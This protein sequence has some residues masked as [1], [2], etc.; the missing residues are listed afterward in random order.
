MLVDTEVAAIQPVAVALVIL[1]FVAADGDLTARL[2]KRLMAGILV[3]VADTPSRVL[4]EGDARR[5]ARVHGVYRLPL[6][7]VGGSDPLAKEYRRAILERAYST[8]VVELAGR[9]VVSFPVRV[10]AL[11]VDDTQLPL[12][13]LYAVAGPI[14]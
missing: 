14:H 1:V 10:H 6:G 11:D 4:A 2:H 13:A 9:V 7:G 3:V 12:A 5:A 8:Q